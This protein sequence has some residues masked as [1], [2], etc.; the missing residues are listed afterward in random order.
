MPSHVEAMGTHGKGCGKQAR[1]QRSLAF[2]FE[3]FCW[4]QGVVGQWIGHT[5]SVQLAWACYCFRPF[6]WKWNQEKKA[7]FIDSTSF[8]LL[9]ILSFCD[10]STLLRSTGK[11]SRVAKQDFTFEV[12]Q[13]HCRQLLKQNNVFYNRV[14]NFYDQN[15]LNLWREIPFNRFLVIFV[16]FKEMLRF[17]FFIIQRVVS[18]LPR[19]CLE[20]ASKQP[21]WPVFARKDFRF[22]PSLLLRNL[23]LYRRS[24]LGYMDWKIWFW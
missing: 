9:S 17:W 23:L 13:S 14:W 3:F 7:R 15:V 10:G 24:Q 4:W 6:F 1:A 19:N 8:K 16:F 2:S 20:I 22:R 18:R 21:I 11:K 12:F 5:E